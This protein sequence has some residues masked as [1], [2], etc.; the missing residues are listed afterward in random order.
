MDCN[1]HE[2]RGDLNGGHLTLHE[3]PLLKLSKHLPLS[4]FDFKSGLA[5][6]IS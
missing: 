2:A 1:E 5:N 3:S 4:Y 6:N